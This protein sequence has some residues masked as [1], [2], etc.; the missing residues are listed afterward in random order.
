L[1]QP[2]G[3]ILVVGASQGI[4]LQIAAEL[5]ETNASLCVFATEH[6][7]RPSLSLNKLLAQYP[8]RLHILRLDALEERDYAQMFTEISHKTQKLDA[9]VNCLGFLHSDEFK[10]EKRI[11]DF[12][13]EHSL[14]AF[15]VN[16]LPVVMLAKHLMPLFRSPSPSVIMSLSARVG[17]I[18]DNGTG[19]WYS[20]RSSKAAHNMFIKNIAIE[21]RRNKCNSVVVSVHPGPTQSRLSEPFQS[22]SPYD[23]VDAVDTG[24]SLL[25][26]MMQVDESMNGCFVDWKAE[27]IHW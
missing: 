26:L 23:F 22:T 27:P 7:S 2:L 4:G 13:P 11:K 17:S 18:R 6:P 16:S 1:N 5:L 8:D 14:Y 15:Q 3:A 10:P 20:Y 21:L 25:S 12:N 24:R 19:G 9:L